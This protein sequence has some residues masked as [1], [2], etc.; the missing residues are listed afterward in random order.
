MLFVYFSS[1][2]NI[3]SPMNKFS[4]LGL[5]TT[6]CNWILDF[7]TNR[8]QTVQI[9]GHTS[10]TLVLNTLYTYDCNPQHGDNS[11][12]K[13]VDNSTI[14][15]WI[16]N[17]DETSYQEDSTDSAEWCTNSLPFSVRK[18]KELI[19]DSR[20]K[21]TMTHTPV[22]ISGAEVEQVN[23]FRFLGISITENLS[24]TWT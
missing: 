11:I 21:E 4:T 20:K 3:I 14:I 24:W 18:T 2:F 7:L 12:V 9:G 13:F 1:A 23:S 19:I 10:S 17:N 8:P 5:S 22:Y 15:C 6:L 16:S